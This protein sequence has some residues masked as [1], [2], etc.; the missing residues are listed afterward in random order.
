M[1]RSSHKNELKKLGV[2]LLG[3]SLKLEILL[4]PLKIFPVHLLHVEALE[5]PDLLRI[6]R[7]DAPKLS[8]LNALMSLCVAPSGATVLP[9]RY[10][11]LCGACDY[12]SHQAVLCACQC[13]GMRAPHTWHRVHDL[14]AP[15]LPLR[16]YASAP[17]GCVPS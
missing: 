8:R 13:A 3:C 2:G 10:A 16:Q 1:W 17:R 4:L 9:T 15:R 11:R 12:A 7:L 6:A 5:A 14:T